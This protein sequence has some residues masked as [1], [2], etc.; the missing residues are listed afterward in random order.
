MFV[1]LTT[2]MEVKQRK[3]KTLDK[4]YRDSGISEMMNDNQS[5]DSHMTRSVKSGDSHMTSSVRSGDS[6][7]GRSSM[8]P[9][10]GLSSLRR[11]SRSRSS[12]G[13]SGGHRGHEV[14]QV[15]TEGQEVT[16]LNW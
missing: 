1:N 3:S 5:A 8:P 6:G 13:S 11:K 10:L 9:G 7:S 15:S 2:G 12:D 4:N 16:Q 14:T